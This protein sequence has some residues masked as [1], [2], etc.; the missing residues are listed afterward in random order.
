MRIAIGSDH[1][2]FILKDELRVELQRWG[3]TVLDMGC[4]S[5][6]PSD[7][8]D[9]AHEVCKAVLE[10]RAERGVL[11]CSTGIGM[12]M[13]ANR[14]AGIRCALCHNCDS[15]YRARTHNDAN[16]I[17]FGSRYTTFL[18]ARAMLQVFLGTHFSGEERHRRRIEHIEACTG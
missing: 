14:H 8:P 4:H 17:A 6:D 18:D 9:Y 12:S 16:V 11:V 3:H 2:G 10:G 13:A 1:A 7:Y 5:T 15:T